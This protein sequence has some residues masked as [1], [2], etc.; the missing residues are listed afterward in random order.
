[1]KWK[2]N[3]TN[4]DNI[5][6]Y[7]ESIINE[8]LNKGY[9]LVAS[10]GTDSQTSGRGYNFAT[11]ILLTTT[12]DLG[13]VIV[14]RGGIV[15]ASTYFISDKIL[16]TKGKEGVNER[17]LLEVSKSIEAA[18]ELAPVFDLYDIKME[19]HADI[20][21]NPRWESNKALQAAVGHI[22]GMGYDFKIKPFAIGAS[23]GADRYC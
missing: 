15:M 19:I 14:G 13:G 21:S 8:E 22:L 5:S 12:E 2:R 6:D 7:L 1:M 16:K 4:I 23:F 11:I 10:I 3:N 18:Y 17:M 20:N 9:K